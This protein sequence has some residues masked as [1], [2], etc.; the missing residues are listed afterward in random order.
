MTKATKIQKFNINAEGFGEVEIRFVG[1][2]TYLG[3]SL[4]H[5]SIDAYSQKIE[6]VTNGINL[7]NF[8]MIYSTG[9]QDLELT[10]N[11]VVDL[12]YLDIRSRGAKITPINHIPEWDPLSDMLF[13]EL[14]KILFEQLKVR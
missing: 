11:T 2:R 3:G 12:L 8:L 10:N 14:E 5:G 6:V 9:Y 13:E 1:D 4:G 7:K